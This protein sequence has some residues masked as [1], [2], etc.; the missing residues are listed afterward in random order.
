MTKQTNKKNVITLE[1]GTKAE[2]R[3]KKKILKV[4]N[5]GSTKLPPKH[6]NKK[7]TSKQVR[8]RE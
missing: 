1:N 5:E 2:I 3:I 6:Q 8:K 7:H 4:K